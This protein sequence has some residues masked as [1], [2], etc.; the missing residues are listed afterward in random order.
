VIELGWQLAIAHGGGEV[1]YRTNKLSSPEIDNGSTQHQKL[2]RQRMAVESHVSQRQKA[3]PRRQHTD[4]E[5]TVEERQ[6]V[7][8][9][10]IWHFRYL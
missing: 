8:R 3:M 5:L 2:P 10:P 9:A 4:N 1:L 6:I 7:F